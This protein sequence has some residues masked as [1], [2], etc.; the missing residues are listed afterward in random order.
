MILP[1]LLPAVLLLG[2]SPSCLVV[3]DNA[4]GKCDIDDSSTAF[5]VD[6]KTLMGCT[7]PRLAISDPLGKLPLPLMLPLLEVEGA[8]RLH[9][10]SL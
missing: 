1:V 7:D 9:Q 8:R 10:E 6:S 3:H 4:N 5:F 2:A